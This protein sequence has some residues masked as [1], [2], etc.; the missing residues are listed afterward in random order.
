MPQKDILSREL[1]KLGG[2]LARWLS[3]WLPND[4][5]E[6]TIEVNSPLE[7]NLDTIFNLLSREG[8]IIEN[9]WMHPH[10]PSVSL[11]VESGF[12]N[13]NPALVKVQ[14]VPAIAGVTKLSIVGTAK[15]GLIKQH[16]GKKAANRIANLLLRALSQT[17][18]GAE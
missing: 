6:L 16:A 4:V 10:R 11:L 12:R 1:G 18:T 17:E 7:Q 13:L 8:K 2:F 3:Q 14:V 15:E 9:Q 5:F